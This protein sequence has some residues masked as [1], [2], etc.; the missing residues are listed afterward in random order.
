MQKRNIILVM[1]RT[2]LCLYLAII[3]VNHKALLTFDGGRLSLT[4][5][6]LQNFLKI[7]FIKCLQ[8]KEKPYLNNSVHR[9]TRLTVTQ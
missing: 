1:M 7:F 6:L 4:A 9:H 2:H 5:L 3:E 8:H